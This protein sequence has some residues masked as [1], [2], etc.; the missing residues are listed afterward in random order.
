MDVTLGDD[1]SIINGI[2]YKSMCDEVMIQVFGKSVR[3]SVSFNSRSIFKS[4]RIPSRV[5]RSLATLKGVLEAVF[6]A[7]RCDEK[8]FGNDVVAVGI[9]LVHDALVPL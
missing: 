7:L 2:I 6:E 1:T 9:V 5:A 3:F 8:C 4:R